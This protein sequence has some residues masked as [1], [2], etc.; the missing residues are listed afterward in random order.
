MI[1]KEDV[2]SL[3]QLPAEEGL[4][5][6]SKKLSKGFVFLISIVLT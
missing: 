4:K 1:S 2:E 6:I 5:F 3:K